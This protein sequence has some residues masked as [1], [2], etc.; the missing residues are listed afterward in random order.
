MES[1]SF[2]V[3][4]PK[5]IKR[6]ADKAKNYTTVKWATVVAT[7]NSGIVPTVTSSGVANIY[8]KGRHLVVYNASDAEENYRVCKFY[9]TV[10]GKMFTISP[11]TAIVTNSAKNGN[12]FN[13]CLSNGPTCKKL[14]SL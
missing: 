5:D 9:V 14:A 1:P 4:C 10:D 2:G 6:F 3:T 12:G 13:C 11:I 7:D 8:Y